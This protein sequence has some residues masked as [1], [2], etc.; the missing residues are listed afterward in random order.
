MP[1]TGQKEIVLFVHGIRSSADAW[2]PLIELL[3]KDD[4]VTA[5]FEF[6]CFAYNTKAV[7]LRPDQVIARI[8]VAAVGLREFID[9]PKFYD[10]EITLVGHS[11]GGLVIQAFL[12]NMLTNGRGEK[13]SA[14][15]QVIMMATPSHGST[16]LS[17]VRKLLGKLFPNPQEEALRVF[18]PNTADRLNFVME[19]VVRAKK[20]SIN[21]WPIPFYVFLAS[22]D[23][24]VAE[25]SARGGFPDENVKAVKGNHFTI[26]TP[27][28]HKDERYSEFV[29]A[30]F[31]PAGHACV[32]EIDLYETK[33][34]VRPAI[35][36]QDFPCKHGAKERMVHTDNIGCIDRAVTFSR[37]NRCREL[38]L[39]QYRTRHEGFL[40]ASTDPPVNEASESEMGE[41]D[42]YGVAT[43]FKFTPKPGQR[44]RSKID[45][46]GGFGKGQRDVHFHIG[47]N[48]Y[49]KKRI[50]S[51][52]LSGY[53]AAGYQVLQRPK[54]HFHANDPGDHGLCKARKL[55]D[56]VEPTHVDDAGIWTWE[57]FRVR[58]GVVDMGWNLSLGQP[59]GE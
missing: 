49:S 33:V 21:E 2:K 28:D 19:H 45:V 55:G 22:D 59:G 32:H 38:F 39:I 24:I 47:R 35:D 43:V 50:Y 26:I 36:C 7:E 6:D 31:N 53:L 44:F 14:I 40:E 1:G 58:Q 48:T 8:D 11:Q 9:S 34:S 30:L 37:Q 41:Y 52:D 3:K 25:S 15:R 16:F 29:E 10:R 12:Y 18:D 23:K 17:P 4:A 20:A 57:F 42:D 56:E 13:L 51:L 27:D 54:L 46:Y 5:R